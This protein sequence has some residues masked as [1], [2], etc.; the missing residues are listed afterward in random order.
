MED[1]VGKN[2]RILDEWRAKFAEDKKSDE[3]YIDLDPAQYFAYD[4]I[5]NKGEFYVDEIEDFASTEWPCRRKPSGKESELWAKAPLRVLILGKDPNGY[6]CEAWDIRTETYYIKGNGIPPQNHEISESIFFQNAACAL[7]GIFHTDLEH[8]IMNYNDIT[9]EDALHFS[10]ELIFARVNCKKETGGPTCNPTILNNA[11]REYFDFLSEQIKT[12]D[13]DII[14]C[15]GKS[16]IIHI[17]NRIYDWS[18]ERVPDAPFAWYDKEKNKLAIDSYHMSWNRGK[19]DVVYYSILRPYFAF[20]Q[21]HPE[22]V[23]HR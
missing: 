20:L 16:T 11:V 1:Y 4:G 15:S 2:Q 7:Y 19:E 10:D 12:L 8:G 13:A 9:W 5:M 14:I 21:L 23:K 22:F 18:F 6:G 17:L 3:E